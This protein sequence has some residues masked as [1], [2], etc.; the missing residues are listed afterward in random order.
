MFPFFHWYTE[1]RC[2]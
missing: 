1:L 2:I